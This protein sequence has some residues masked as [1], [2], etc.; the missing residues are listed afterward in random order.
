MFTKKTQA[1]LAS[2][3]HATC[4]IPVKS[5]FIKALKNGIFLTWPGL[6]VKLI[7]THPPKIEATI[8]GNLDQMR[9]N[10]TSTN[11]EQLALETEADFFPRQR[12]KDSLFS[13][14]GLSDP[15]NGKLYTGLTGCFLVTKNRGIQYILILYTYDTNEI[16]V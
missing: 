14:I 4:F 7:A 12:K 1:E 6:M 8:F 2:F 5:T 16:L 3:L 15:D 10:T 11:T 13:A 9:K